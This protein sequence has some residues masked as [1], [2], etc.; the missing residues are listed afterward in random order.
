MVFPLR[1][2]GSIN[3]NIFLEAD[4]PCK[5]ADIG[6]VRLMSICGRRTE[7]DC[8]RLRVGSLW[9]RTLAKSSKQLLSS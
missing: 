6:R 4:G 1:L 8:G 9:L 7:A 3:M 2:H 5:V